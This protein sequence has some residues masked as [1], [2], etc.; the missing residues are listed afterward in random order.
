MWKLLV[1]LVVVKLYARIH[2]FKYFFRCY[3]KLFDQGCGDL[4]YQ[5]L[6][7][8]NLFFMWC[9]QKTVFLYF[10]FQSLEVGPIQ[11]WINW[12]TFRFNGKCIENKYFLDEDCKVNRF[13]GEVRWKNISPFW[14]GCIPH[15]NSGFS[16]LL[17]S[18]ILKIYLVL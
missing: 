11:R 7:I 8:T 18:E 5:T 16:N 13:S 3:N 4:T 17:L 12:A 6:W 9:S 14:N 2:K 10:H 1:V 15:M